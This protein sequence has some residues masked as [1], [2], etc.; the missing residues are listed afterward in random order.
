[1]KRL[2]I[3]WICVKRCYKKINVIKS[4]G[5]EF[6]YCKD[7]KMIMEI[8]FF[9]WFRKEVEGCYKLCD[10]RSCFGVIFYFFVV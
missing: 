6:I 4:E 9:V 1:M 5:K 3:I 10:W 2:Y 7:Y 8:S